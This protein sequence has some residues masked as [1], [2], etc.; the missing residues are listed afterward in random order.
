MSRCFTRARNP[1]QKD[2]RRAH[3]LGTARALL[4]SGVELRAMSL[5]ELA[6]RAGMA[7]ANVYRY[8]E[9]RE[10]V[11]LALLAAEGVRW[12]EGLAGAWQGERRHEMSLDALITLLARSLG[13][14][15]LLC[16]LTA[17]LPSVL[18]QNLSEEAIRSFKRDALLNFGEIARFLESRCKALSAAAYIEFLNDTA[19]AIMGLYPATHPAPAAARALSAP[20]LRFFRR[21][22]TEELERFMRALATD[23][24]ARPAAGRTTAPAAAVR[25]PRVP[26]RGSAPPRAPRARA[27]P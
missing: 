12:F 15:P 26:A 25:E 23:R 13:R 24:A 8:F 10:A 20:E 6:R 21:D 9:T 16:A 14:E 7:K 1:E 22:F 3:L 4:E 11:L 5:N 18:E 19:W 17:A 2:E 27:E